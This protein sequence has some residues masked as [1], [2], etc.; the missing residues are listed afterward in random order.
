MDN[1][2]YARKLEGL[3][4]ITKRMAEVEQIFNDLCVMEDDQPGGDSME[5][6]HLLR[7]DIDDLNDTVVHLISAVAP[8]VEASRPKPITAAQMMA[9]YAASLR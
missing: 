7:T 1:N 5:E 3:K 9:F 6:Y 2:F 4:L 8:M